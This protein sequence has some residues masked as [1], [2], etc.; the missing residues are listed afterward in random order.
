MK[1]TYF[2]TALVA[3]AG[4]GAVLAQGLRLPGG[5]DA[6]L[7]TLRTESM[8]PQWRAGGA[9]HGEGGP[10]LATS[11]D[12]VTGEVGGGV[13]QPL[14]AGLSTLLET[15]EVHADGATREWSMLGQVAAE[16]GEG[17]GVKAGLRHS[18]LGLHD[19]PLHTPATDATSSADLGMLTFQRSWSRYRGAYTY[20]AGRADTGVLASGHS[21]QFDYFYNERS[22]VGLAYT[23]SQQVESFTNLGLTGTPDVANVGIAGEHWLS[24]AWALNYRALVEEDQG[25]GLKPE[26]RVGLHLRF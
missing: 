7:D 22:S 20:Y 1:W 24:D 5:F 3:L 18:E 2:G 10:A 11:V 21:V 15:S 9:P 26:L 4:N 23:V 12:P 6:N 14:S 19:Q 25:E 13:Y 8:R 16:L 17:W